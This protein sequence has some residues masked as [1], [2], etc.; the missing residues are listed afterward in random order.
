MFCGFVVDVWR[1][2]DDVDVLVVDDASS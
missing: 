1:A 2:D